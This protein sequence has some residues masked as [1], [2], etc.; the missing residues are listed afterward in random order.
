M[1]RT[2]GKPEDKMLIVVFG[3]WCQHSWTKY[4]YDNIVLKLL[5]LQCKNEITITVLDVHVYEYDT[6]KTW[7]NWGVGP[8]KC[9]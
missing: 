6:G 2:G 1:I 8:F 3:L 5:M 9:K 7:W 4:I